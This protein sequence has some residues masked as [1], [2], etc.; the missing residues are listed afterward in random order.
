MD[1]ANITQEGCVHLPVGSGTKYAW[2]PSHSIADVLVAVRNNMH[3]YDVCRLS[4]TI[5]NQSYI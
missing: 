3:L 1:L 4:G 2:D 5:S